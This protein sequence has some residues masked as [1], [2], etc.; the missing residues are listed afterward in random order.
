MEKATFHDHLT[1]LRE[2]FPDCESITVPQA[3][4]FYGCKPSTLLADKTFPAHKTG[5]RGRYHRVM[6]IN[7]A[8][9]L[10]V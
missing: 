8:R 10:S 1:R 9:W 2:V 4:K 7:F 3:A 6:L 5:Q